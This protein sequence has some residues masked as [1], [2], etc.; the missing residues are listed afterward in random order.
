M[1]MMQRVGLS[2]VRR[3]YFSRDAEKPKCVT[4][5]LIVFTYPENIPRC[6]CSYTAE[7]ANNT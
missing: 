6:A 2:K 3:R 1:I 7:T 5:G 4:A